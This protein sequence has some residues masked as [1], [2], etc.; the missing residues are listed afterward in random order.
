MSLLADKKIL[1]LGVANEKSIAWGIA[2]ALK[3]HGARIA[4]TYQND[5]LQ[6]RVDPL[7][8]ELDADFMVEMD[9]TNDTHYPRLRDTIKEKWGTFDV[10]V[11]SL[12]FADRADLKVAF[13]Q[14]SRKGFAMACDISAFSLVGLSNYLK[15]IMMSI[16]NIIIPYDKKLGMS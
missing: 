15:E 2:R 10:I 5:Q 6:K 4:L 12:A 7:A 3:G 14:T 9:V 8:T 16:I 1:I 13:S 11:H